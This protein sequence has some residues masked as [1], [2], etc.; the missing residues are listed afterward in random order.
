MTFIF[1]YVIIK[2]LHSRD[3]WSKYP[4][5][6]SATQTPKGERRRHEGVRNHGRVSV[7]VRRAA[8]ARHGERFLPG[9]V[10]RAQARATPPRG[11]QGVPVLQ[12]RDDPGAAEHVARVP[13]GGA[14]TQGRPAVGDPPPVRELRREPAA[15]GSPGVHA[16]PEGAGA[17][18][19]LGKKKVQ[20]AL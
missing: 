2:N 1:C 4:A 7:G 18:D 9:E 20:T 11:L 13:E 10:L 3:L 5:L 14:G 6:V 15:L 12:R 8:L 17:L 19:V 16:Q